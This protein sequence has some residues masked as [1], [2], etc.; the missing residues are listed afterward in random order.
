MSAFSSSLRS[1]SS[2]ASPPNPSMM[3][4]S[5]FVAAGWER[6][7][8]SSRSTTP[9]LTGGAGRG[10]SGGRSGR[11]LAREPLHHLGGVA[12]ADLQAAGMER[13]ELRDEPDAD[14]G[15]QLDL[16]DLPGGG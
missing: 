14:G 5:S 10:R 8:A 2:R 4:K 6:R 13:Y 9:Y 12:H 1:V 7:L 11:G 3:Q 16:G 15:S